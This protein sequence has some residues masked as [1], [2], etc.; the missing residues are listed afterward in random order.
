MLPAFISVNLILQAVV[1]N[2]R[3]QRFSKTGML[4]GFFTKAIVTKNPG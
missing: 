3:W 1:A 4:S 2:L